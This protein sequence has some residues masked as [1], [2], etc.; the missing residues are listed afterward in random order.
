[1]TLRQAGTLYHVGIGRA[2]KGRR[3]VLLVDGFDV[4]VLT[5]EGELLR[6]FVLDPSRI[7]QPTGK[8][9][10]PAKVSTMS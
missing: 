9:R 2:F 4:T 8:P 10:Y 7:Y 6:R 3:V 1:M 5:E